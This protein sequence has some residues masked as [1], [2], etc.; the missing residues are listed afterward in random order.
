MNILKKFWQSIATQFI[1]QKLC[2]SVKNKIK[3]FV[4][5]FERKPLNLDFNMENYFTEEGR[6]KENRQRLRELYDQYKRIENY[7]P[8]FL[9]YFTAIGIFI[10][11]L[12]AFGINHADLFYYNFITL[13]TV[14]AFIYTCHLIWIV[15]KGNKWTHDYLPKGVYE[16]YDEDVIKDHPELKKGTDEFNNE[17]LK[18]YYQ[19]LEGF[20]E[21]NLDTYSKKRKNLSLIWK[22][23]IVSLILLSLNI[24]YLKT[25]K[26]K[27][28][29][30]EAPKKVVVIE[31][32]NKLD[33]VFT[34]NEIEKIKEI[35]HDE[36]LKLKNGELKGEL[37]RKTIQN[38]K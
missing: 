9:A 17:I 15:F 29:I 3:T 36:F 34:P 27:E 5:R 25:V 13:L 33:D 14:S 20:I 10:F 31:S 4:E 28:D 19:D 23:M 38:N 11:D 18:L 12:I 2:A 8:I 6:V 35:V 24:T 30:N 37:I 7:Y 26:M 16:D 1:P 32:E 22:P 21:E